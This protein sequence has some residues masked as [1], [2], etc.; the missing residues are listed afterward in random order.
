MKP[1]TPESF[2]VL[3]LFTAAVAIAGASPGALAEAPALPA[4]VAPEGIARPPFAFRDAD[5]ALLDAVQRGSFNFLWDD[6]DPV[7]G[8]V[9]DR[10]SKDIISVGGVGFQ[11]S[12]IPIG[13][14][15]GWITRE[16]GNERVVRILRALVNNPNN[17]KEGHYY[18]YLDFA[19]ADAAHHGYERVVSTIDSSLLLAGAL[20]AGAYFGGEARTIADQMFDEVNWNFFVP[21]D[22]DVANPAE[23][24]HVTLGWKPAD[25]DKPT[26]E[27]ALLPFFWVDSGDEHK[28]VTFLGVCAPRPERRLDVKHY[29][30]LRRALGSDAGGPPFVWF[31]WSGALFVGFFAHCWIDYAG[32]GPDN[33][34]A[35]GQ[36]C[37][38]SVDWWENSRRIV[39]MHRRK[40]IE[41]PRN[42][43]TLGEHAWG[44]TACDNA[45]GYMVPDLF[46]TLLPMPGCRPEFDFSQVQPEDDFGDGTVA[47]YGA[48]CSIIFEPQASV[49]ALRYY[50]SLTRADGS[51]MLWK[52]PAK[53]GHGFQDSFNLGTGWVA[54]D[55]VAI[56]HGPM[57]LIIENARTGRVWEWF[58]D[59]PVVKAGKERLGLRSQ[60]SKSVKTEQNSE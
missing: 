31:P 19:T 59:V 37:R 32:L 33:P 2:R 22:E 47:P 56:D 11:L 27:G 6:C 20:T 17:R 41:N 24:G 46:P 42:L 28:L 57:I 10:S 52:D 50:K 40:A 44:L 25:P 36:T 54:P 45:A 3:K 8:M 48:G 18:H 7:T 55:G 29:Y 58:G 38:T 13:V 12:A 49:A 51:P 60:R 21:R 23:R 4:I 1:I 53:G 9:R 30:S 5:E 15:R 43:P 16:Q 39:A 35:F 14:E 34:A 26:G